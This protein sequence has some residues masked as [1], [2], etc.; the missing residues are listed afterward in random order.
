[1]YSLLVSSTSRAWSDGIRVQSWPTSTDA[2]THTCA[3]H[4]VTI[5]LTLFRCNANCAQLHW[6]VERERERE[7]E[8]FNGKSRLVL[9]QSTV[10]IILLA[11]SP[12]RIRKAGDCE[13]CCRAPLN[14]F[15]KPPCPRAYYSSTHRT[16]AYICTGNPV[17][18]F[19]HTHTYTR[20][21]RCYFSGQ[22]NIR[23]C[24]PSRKIASKIPSGLLSQA[25][26]RIIPPLWLKN[27]YILGKNSAVPLLLLRSF[28]CASAWAWPLCFRLFLR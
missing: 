9:I 8:S 5:F 10:I 12:N 16:C 18:P 1:M 7:R 28:E 27:I 15:V 14:I 25:K 20:T 19:A 4:V 6:F 3:S 26:K 2:H 17:H 13:S 22:F 11:G 23:Q 24:L 21:L